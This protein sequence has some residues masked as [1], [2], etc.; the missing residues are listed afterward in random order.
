MQNF[1]VIGSGAWGTALAQCIN[2]GGQKVCLWAREKEVV[3]C[4]LKN[5]ENKRFLPGVSL[6]KKIVA[7]N[8]IN[9]ALKGA[10]AVLIV[11]PA[12]FFR[13]TC[14]SLRPI[15]STNIP[16]VIC[17]KGIEVKSGLL[18]S[19][20][21]ASILP[22][23]PVAILSGPTFAQEVALG[24]PT[25][26]TLAC[27]NPKLKQKLIK[28]LKECGLRPYGSEDVIG[29]EIGGAVKNIIAIASGITIG[30]KL[31]DNARAA[32]IS[33]GFAE[34]SRLA[35]AKGGDTET[36]AGLCGIG[37]LLLTCTSLQS[38]NF[39]LGVKLGKGEKLSN[40]LSKTEAVT[41]GVASAKAVVTLA[42]KCQVEMPISTAIAEI[43]NEEC[44]I[45]EVIERLLLRPLSKD[46]SC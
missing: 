19:E 46:Q 3:D 20:V 31:G 24:L 23:N 22:Q 9:Q 8:D 39:S 28:P 34:I 12:Q 35:E 11:V 37:D 4:I 43:L 10:N 7:T 21:C 6:D 29:A 16:V 36:L 17:T 40:I 32:L 15:I 5:S 26:V 13:A 41:E 25:A 2:R 38:R 1:A 30:R 33:R 27:R 14:I 45:D 42:K 18:M 44:E